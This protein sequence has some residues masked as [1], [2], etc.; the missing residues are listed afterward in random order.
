MRRKPL[1]G[2]ERSVQAERTTQTPVPKTSR[3]SSDQTSHRTKEEKA[4]LR[5]DLP[6]KR[7][8]IRFVD[9]TAFSTLYTGK[10]TGHS[11]FKG[12]DTAL[13][14]RRIREFDMFMQGRYEPS[15]KNYKLDEPDPYCI[16]C[17]KN[18]TG[19]KKDVS[20]REWR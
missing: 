19:E 6:G 16:P 20:K 5:I 7:P 18:I 9:K 2:R 8:D 14:E 15:K 3:E 12:A 11:V 13:S 1:I 10:D 17:A 4:F